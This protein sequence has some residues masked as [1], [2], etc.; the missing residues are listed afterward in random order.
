MSR[1]WQGIRLA[2]VLI[3]G[4]GAGPVWAQKSIDAEQSASGSLATISQTGSLG[5]TAVTVRQSVGTGNG[6]AIGQTNND[7]VVSASARQEGG[8]NVANIDQR[9]N[10]GTL[11]ADV[12]QSGVANLANV[13]QVGNAGAVAGISQIGEANLADVMQTQTVDAH[14]SVAQDGIAN[15]ASVALTGTAPGGPAAVAVEQYGTGNLASLA[16][17]PYAQVRQEG[18]GNVVTGTSFTGPLTVSQ[19]GVDNRVSVLP[20]QIDM[21][22]TQAGAGNTA[23]VSGGGILSTSD[24]SMTGTANAAVVWFNDPAQSQFALD[25]QGS[26][27]TATVTQGGGFRSGIHASMNGH[28]NVATVDQGDLRDSYVTLNQAGN[29]NSADIRQAQPGDYREVLVGPPSRKPAT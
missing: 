11:V 4:V 2:G 13:T 18:A 15:T 24:I 20:G 28:A 8:D 7:A 19:L 6:I 1:K 10:T 26:D 3:L 25:M 14:V 16:G 27:Q 12:T 22:V 23:G 9:D 17:V 29:G 21:H 5:S